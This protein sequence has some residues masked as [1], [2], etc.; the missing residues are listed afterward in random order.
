FDDKALEGQVRQQELL[1]SN[2]GFNIS[3]AK[4]EIKYPNGTLGNPNPATGP[5]G[6]FTFLTDKKAFENVVGDLPKNGSTI[7]V[8]RDQLNQLEDNLGLVP[9]SLD[10]GSVLR[11]FDNFDNLPPSSPLDGNELFRGPG[12]HLQDGSPEMIVNPA[13]IR[14]DN[15][16]IGE[17]WTIEVVE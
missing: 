1:D 11:R 8:S 10:S 6:G 14:T 16:N 5:D 17:S 3:G 2:Q 12:K 7:K 13:Q 4:D 9:G 15:P